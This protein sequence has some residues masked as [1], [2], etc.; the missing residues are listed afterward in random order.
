[1]PTIDLLNQ[2]TSIPPNDN[3]EALRSGLTK[4]QNNVNSL[5][6]QIHDAVI[7]NKP[8]QVPSGIKVPGKIFDPV[9]GVNVLFGYVITSDFMSFCDYK[10]LARVGDLVFVVGIVGITVVA[11]IGVITSGC[12]DVRNNAFG[13]GTPY[14]GGVGGCVGSPLFSATINADFLNPSILGGIDSCLNSGNLANCLPAIIQQILGNCQQSSLSPAY[15]PADSFHLDNALKKFGADH[16]GRLNDKLKKGFCGN[17]PVDKLKFSVNGSKPSSDPCDTSRSGNIASTPN[18]TDLSAPCVS[19]H[20]KYLTAKLQDSS[21]LSFSDTATGYMSRQD[22]AVISLTQDIKNYHDA[23]I[24]EEA[25]RLLNGLP[26][27]FPSNSAEAINI[28]LTAANFVGNKQAT[29]SS[30]SNVV[31]EMKNLRAKIADFASKPVD[32]VVDLVKNDP[33]L[34]RFFGELVDQRQNA[35]ETLTP[36]PPAFA[37]VCPEPVIDENCADLNEL[38]QLVND[39]IKNI[40][41]LVNGK[42]GQTGLIG[43][44]LAKAGVGN[45]KIAT[46]AAGMNPID[47]MTLFRGA[48][49]DKINKSIA[50]TLRVKAYLEYS[51]DTSMSLVGD[52]ATFDSVFAASPRDPFTGSILNP[53]PLTAILNEIYAKCITLPQQAIESFALEIQQ[54]GSD[55]RQFNFVSMDPD[56]VGTAPPLSVMLANPA[57]LLPSSN[58]GLIIAS[59]QS[60]RRRKMLLRK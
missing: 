39:G 57:V 24:G 34:N 55:I 48:T 11:E 46:G 5:D 2:S 7:G 47:S 20:M 52:W 16:I 22:I 3:I 15:G 19:E 49:I 6:S 40:L 18:T 28:A 33:E 30:I 29:A 45:L 41:E 50:Q 31:N 42:K 25:R 17:S 53:A 21:G 38:Q 36:P 13:S 23:K 43:Q 10:P 27:D 1:M 59:S 56:L 54:L 9:F 12:M 26:S 14:G 4:F 44:A 32:S 8:P 60:F 58:I 35:L 37:A 51:A